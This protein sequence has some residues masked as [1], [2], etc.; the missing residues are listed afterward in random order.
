[1]IKRGLSLKSLSK[2]KQN[3]ASVLKR[4]KTEQKIIGSEK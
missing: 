2:V 1:M 3:N 4:V